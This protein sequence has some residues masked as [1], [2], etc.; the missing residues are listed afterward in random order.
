M[1]INYQ[2]D[3][4]RG[5]SCTTLIE[6]ALKLNINETYQGINS[7]WATQGGNDEGET[8]GIPGLRRGLP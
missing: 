1:L 3:L 7:Q 4:K 6:D 5:E 8:G 2:Y